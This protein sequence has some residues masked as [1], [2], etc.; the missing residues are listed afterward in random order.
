MTTSRLLGQQLKMEVFTSDEML[1]VAQVRLI[2]SDVWAV[3]LTQMRQQGELLAVMHPCNSRRLV[4]AD[5]KFNWR[6]FP[7]GAQPGP[8]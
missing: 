8:G 4:G 5:R 3:Q 7:V 1:T 6:I 2:L